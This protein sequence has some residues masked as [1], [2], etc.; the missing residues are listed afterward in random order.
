MYLIM[1]VNKDAFVISAVVIYRASVRCW[2]WDPVI[3]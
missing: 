3:S 2:A 1:T